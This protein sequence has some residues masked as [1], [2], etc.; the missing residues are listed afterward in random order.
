MPARS[1]KPRRDRR[2]RGARSPWRGRGGRRAPSIT[3]STRSPT[4]GASSANV[5]AIELAAVVMAAVLVIVVSCR[6]ATGRPRAQLARLEHPRGHRDRARVVVGNAARSACG[7]SRRGSAWVARTASADAT[8]SLASSTRSA[9][10]P[11]RALPRAS[12]SAARAG[13]GIDH[14]D[15]ARRARPQLLRGAR[16]IASLARTRARGRR[17][18]RRARRCRWSRA[19]R[20]RARERATM[21]PMPSHRSF[22]MSTLQHTQPPASSSTSPPRPTISCVSIEMRPSS[23]T[24]TAIRLPCGAASMRLSAVVL[25]APSQPVRIVNGTR[26]RL[27][28]QRLNSARST[29][30]ASTS[31]TN[32]RTTNASGPRLGADVVDVDVRRRH[33]HDR[34]VR[35]R[36]D[37]S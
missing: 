31:R 14:A 34:D 4:S 16:A 25:P 20:D 10:T 24:S 5:T 11:A 2:R 33:H 29:T 30:F 18:S 12:S 22:L 37:R 21:S 28:A 13:L 1:T 27:R 8:S 17:G 6:R 3:A 32:G 23:L 15:H 35:G 9:A 7:A 36:R 19:R 26:S